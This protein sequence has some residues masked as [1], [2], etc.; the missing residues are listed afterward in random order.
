MAEVRGEVV[1]GGE[2]TWCSC[3]VEWGQRK[4]GSWFLKNKI[5]KL[6]SSEIGTQRIERRRKEKVK[7]KR[8]GRDRLWPLMCIHFT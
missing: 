4:V 7:E 8:G 1:L 2:L 6:C 5:R 3:H